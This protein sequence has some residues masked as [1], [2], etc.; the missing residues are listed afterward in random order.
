MALNWEGSQAHS[1]LVVHSWY[2]D[3]LHR[4][5]A[6]I[7]ETTDWA[8][9]ALISSIGSVFRIDRLLCSDAHQPVCECNILLCE[10]TNPNKTLTQNFEPH[11]ILV[12]FACFCHHS[13]WVLNSITFVAW[14][15]S[16]MFRKAL[17]VRSLPYCWFP[18]PSYVWKSI[19]LYVINYE[20]LHGR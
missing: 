13:C 10:R 3:A 2:V 17:N 14:Q 15:C 7:I 16:T 12:V 5:N 18:C 11:P 1:G 4:V 20:Y 8:F 19:H 9:A 6:L